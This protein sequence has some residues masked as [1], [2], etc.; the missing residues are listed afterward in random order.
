[1]ATRF[2]PCV[3]GDEDAPGPVAFGVCTHLGVVCDKRTPRHVGVL[4]SDFFGKVL[5]RLYGQSP[6]F[7]PLRH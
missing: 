4:G 6:Y 5:L 7:L 1:M 3:T 2:V